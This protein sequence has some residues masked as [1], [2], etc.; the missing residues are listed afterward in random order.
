MRKK[1]KIFSMDIKA[2]YPSLRKQVCKD[3]M[4]WIINKTE[5]SVEDMDWTQV[6]RY[7][8]VMMSPEDIEKE[9]LTD[10]IPGRVKVTRRKLTMHSLSVNSADQDWL[11]SAPPNELQQRKLLGL[12]MT[13]AVDVIMSN[14]TFMLGDDVFLQ[15]DGGPIGLEFA[16]AIAR[17][18]MMWWD[19]L[20]LEKVNSEGI[21]LPL[22]ERYVD[23]S[24]QAVYVPDGVDEEQLMIK[25]KQ[26]ADS[27]LPGIITEMDMPKNY[28]DKKLPILD[29]KCF[30][31]DGFLMYEHYEKPMA[32]KLI[33]SSR[34]AHSSQTKKSVLIN[35][36]VRRI[37]NTSP[38]LSWDDYVVPHLDE[39]CRR[40]MA[41]GYNQ[42]YRKEILRNAIK[43]YDSKVKN[44]RDGIQPLNRPRGYRKSERRVEKR[45]K[46]KTWGTRGGFTAP[47]IVP[48]TPG[49]ELAQRMRKVCE[50]EAIPGLRFKVSE[51]GGRTIERQLQKSNPTAS[52]ECGRPGCDPCEQPG[53]NGGTKLCHKSN[54]VYKYVCQFQDCDASYIGET[55][56]NL[57]SRNGEHVYKYKG[58]KNRT[59][60]KLQDQSF[61]FQHQTSKHDGLPSNFKSEIVR[62]YSDCLSRQAG[63]AIFINKMSGEILNSKSEFYQPSIV[64]I[65]REISRGL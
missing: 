36:C 51:R 4:Q 33:I 25:L 21:Y 8:A 58:G 56:R 7:I 30:V 39:Y 16:G 13:I 40:M 59:S 20:Y 41:A 12:V 45:M 27:I 47:I 48:C 54:V 52:D 35:E 10:V 1:S 46:K 6:T 63:E 18:V 57:F 22:Y 44:D 3:A 19:H 55:S 42:S 60:K 2:L 29:M 64:T 38:R 26:I 65:R 31:E 32:T 17:V 14:H 49:G 62:S 50:A 15:T 53:G 24:N 11:P 34:S 43:I 23:D 9:G 61:M 28:P 37:L 5:V